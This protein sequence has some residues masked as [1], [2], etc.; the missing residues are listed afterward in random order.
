LSLRLN[1]ILAKT[2]M[3]RFHEHKDIAFVHKRRRRP[4]PMRCCIG[5]ESVLGQEVSRV[6]RDR[7]ITVQSSL[8]AAGKNMD[9][10]TASGSAVRLSKAAPVNVAGTDKVDS[11]DWRQNRIA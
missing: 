4:L 6:G 3:F 7:G 10:C 9:S 1:P 5:D 8:D 11:H 2:A